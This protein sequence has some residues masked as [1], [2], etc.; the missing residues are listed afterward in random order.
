MIQSSLAYPSSPPPTSQSDVSAFAQLAPGVVAGLKSK[1]AWQKALGSARRSSRPRY[2][3]DYGGYDGYYGSGGRT[4]RSNY[5][6]RGH[7]KVATGT[8]SRFLGHLGKAVKS[9]VLWGAGISVFLNVLAVSERRLSGAQAS[10]NVVG[11][12]MSA[13]VG[14]AAGAAASALGTAVLGGALGTGM[15]LTVA[16]AACGIGG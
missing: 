14:G 9:A 8:G 16:A 13:A 15:G 11:D 5:S 3:G 1:R 2:P 4:Y 10:A 7:A 12:V 6:Q